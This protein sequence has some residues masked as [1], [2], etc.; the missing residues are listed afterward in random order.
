MLRLAHQSRAF[1][2]LVARAAVVGRA[3]SVSHIRLYSD[4]SSVPPQE[5]KAKPS[6]RSEKPIDAATPFAEPSDIPATDAALL[7]RSQ[8]VEELQFE[9]KYT[10]DAQ[11]EDALNT[12]EE[13]GFKTKQNLDPE[14]FSDEELDPRN[15]NG[16]D[17][18]EVVA[19]FHNRQF[20]MGADYAQSQEELNQLVRAGRMS[21]ADA[22]IIRS[23]Y[24]GK[25][26]LIEKFEEDDDLSKNDHVNE[27]MYDDIPTAG[28]MQVEKVRKMRHLQ[29][30]SAYVLPRLVDYHVP[31]DL[32]ETD[33]KVSPLTFKYISYTGEEA[34]DEEAKVVCYFDPAN[35]G[36]SD[37]GLHKFKLLAGQNYD[38]TSGQCK[39][40][41]KRHPSAPENKHHLVAQIL[42]LKSEAETGDSFEDVPLDTR[43][44][45]KKAERAAKRN[46]HRL[47]QFP[48][49]WNRPE[50]KAKQ[51]AYQALF[52]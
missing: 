21:G 17:F 13:L 20:K 43:H 19:R 34:A 11:T 2:G 28:H 10:F 3:A 35:L 48:E 50:D 6:F 12:I 25:Q 51:T 1:P 47:A 15:W 49:E 23:A 16:L 46:Q 36:L 31:F 7:P 42:K 45:R 24:Y 29:R 8:R 9:P 41:S 39:F 38:A 44:A 37:K 27:F 52:G 30:M 32:K 33:P 5:P 14:R 40:A 26:S 18:H 22:S 4:S